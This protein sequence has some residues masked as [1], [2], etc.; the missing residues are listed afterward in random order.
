[1][2]GYTDIIYVCDTV[3]GCQIL[4]QLRDAVKRPWVSTCFNHPKVVQDFARIHSYPPFISQNSGLVASLLNSGFYIFSMWFC[5]GMQCFLGLL[6]LYPLVN[7]YITMENQHVFHG[8][9]HYFD[10]AIWGLLHINSLIPFLGKR[11]TKITTISMGKS[12]ASRMWQ[13][14]SRSTGWLGD[15]DPTLRFGKNDENA[16]KND[17]KSCSFIGK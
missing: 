14:G 9:I 4:H 10:W 17:G 7:V 13:V 8:K 5:I 15:L 3:D 1:M 2:T 16:Q 12:M 6:P 11:W